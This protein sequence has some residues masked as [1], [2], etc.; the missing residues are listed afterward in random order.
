MAHHHHLLHGRAVI[1]LHLLLRSSEAI[2]IYGNFSPSKFNIRSDC[3]Q[4]AVMF[5]NEEKKT[6]NCLQFFLVDNGLEIKEHRNTRAE[7]TLQASWLTLSGLLR[8]V[9]EKYEHFVGILMVEWHEIRILFCLW[10]VWLLSKETSEQSPNF[11]QSNVILLKENAGE[12]KKL[13][14]FVRNSVIFS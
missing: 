9:Q 1:I 8:F 10:N 14:L 2:Q 11:H 4:K 7:H 12:S 13:V 6:P 3:M 5:W